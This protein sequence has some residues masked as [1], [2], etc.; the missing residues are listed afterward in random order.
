MGVSAARQPIPPANP[1]LARI[2]R[3]FAPM[4]ELLEKN[5]RD[6]AD[7]NRVWDE[8]LAERA[9]ISR[10]MPPPIR[11]EPPPQGTNGE[12]AKS[13]PFPARALRQDKP[14]IGLRTPW[15]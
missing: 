9:P 15:Q 2:N 14:G 6:R 4:M 11:P 12:G 3:D 1:D 5:Q 8:L 7:D 10:V 13:H